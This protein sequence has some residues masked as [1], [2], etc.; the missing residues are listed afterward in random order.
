[1]QKLLS[2]SILCT[3]YTVKALY[4]AG[5]IFCG[6]PMNISSL[7][8]HFADFKFVT[9]L[10]YTA[11]TFVFLELNDSKCQYTLQFLE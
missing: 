9:L 5:I 10:Q 11:K 7:E 6:F 4:F 8:F 2:C 1:M 3:K